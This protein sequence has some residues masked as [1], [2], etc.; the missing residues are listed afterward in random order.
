[1]CCGV[2]TIGN[3]LTEVNVTCPAGFKPVNQFFD[4]ASEVKYW[5]IVNNKYPL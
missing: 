4:F 5:D 3:F 1:M 2:D